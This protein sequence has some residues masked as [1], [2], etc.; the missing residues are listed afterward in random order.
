MM[1]MRSSE[2][3]ST[4]EANALSMLALAHVGDAV[5]ELLVRSFLASRGPAS[6]QDL[7]RKTVSY[8]RA[9]S[10]AEAA[11]KI[12][13]ILDEEETAVYKRGRNCRVHGIPT[14]ANPAEYHSATGLEALLGWLYLQGRTDRIDDLFQ[15]VMGE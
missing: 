2:P 13:P 10:Q 9:E 15:T 14:H 11:R 1:P 7:H 6:V 5:F 3:L 8:V 12:L 4:A